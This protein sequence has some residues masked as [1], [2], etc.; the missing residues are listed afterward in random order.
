MRTLRRF[1]MWTAAMVLVASTAQAVEVGD[2]AA[3]PDVQL[4]D[5]TR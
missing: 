1:L 5:G 2:V 4:L 3:L